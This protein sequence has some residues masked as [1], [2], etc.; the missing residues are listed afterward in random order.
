M[1]DRPASC[2]RHRSSG[3]IAITRRIAPAT[4]AGSR[5]G[6]TSPAA[7]A[8][9]LTASGLPAC[10]VVITGTP[11]ACASISTTGVPSSSPS[12]AVALGSTTAA[13]PPHHLCHLRPL[14]PTQQPDA[15]R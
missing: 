15:I 1:C 5:S 8:A 2:S 14:D 4:A 13:A 10:R 6:T 12:V 3:G 9:A 7:S 11:S